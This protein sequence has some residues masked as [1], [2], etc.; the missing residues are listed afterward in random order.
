MSATE[1]RAIKVGTFEYPADQDSVQLTSWDST[2]DNRP[3]GVS[4]VY[5]FVAQEPLKYAGDKRSRIIYIGMT[6]GP[7]LRRPLQSLGDSLTDRRTCRPPGVSRIDI[8]F[9]PDRE[10]RSL[11][12]ALLWLFSG[13]QGQPLPWLNAQS[14]NPRGGSPDALAR[15]RERPEWRYINLE[16]WLRRYDQERA[17]R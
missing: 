13:G 15:V 4:G 17:E 16:C 6:D 7:G 1:P 12:S 14:R 2:H 11:E 9:I 8:V 3:A 10:P 5:L